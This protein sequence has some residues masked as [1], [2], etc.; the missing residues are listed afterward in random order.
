[1]L[2][3]EHD[4]ALDKHRRNISVLGFPRQKVATL[5]EQDALAGWSQVVG[6]AASACSSP[7]DNHVKLV[8]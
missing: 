8:L 2:L 7:N 1:M 4:A 5:E 3:V 6:K